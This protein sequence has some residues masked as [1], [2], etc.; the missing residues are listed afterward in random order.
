MS[1]DSLLTF[2]LEMLLWYK[3]TKDITSKNF[4]GS[5]RISGNKKEKNT[6]LF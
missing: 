5:K 1:I 6:L 4:L 2:F 3:S